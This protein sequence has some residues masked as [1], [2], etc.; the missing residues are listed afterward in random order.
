MKSTAAKNIKPPKH[1]PFVETIYVL[2]SKL[3]GVPAGKYYAVFKKR[4]KEFIFN[5]KA[6]QV[7]LDGAMFQWEVR[8]Q[9]VMVVRAIS[10][11]LDSVKQGNIYRVFDD[12]ANDERYIVDENHDKVLFDEN[13]FKWELL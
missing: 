6:E 1:R 13:I 3:E 4:E 8:D 2:A 12:V 5:E 7:L 10:S 11:H 9:T